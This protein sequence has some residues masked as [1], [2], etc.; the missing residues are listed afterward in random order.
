MEYGTKIGMH[1]ELGMNYVQTFGI[2]YGIR[3]IKRYRILDG[4]TYDARQAL[5][6]TLWN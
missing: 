6:N 5:R 2:R 3:Y 1:C 4:I